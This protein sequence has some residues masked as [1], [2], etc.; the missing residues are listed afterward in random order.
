M[1]AAR[2][3]CEGTV[4]A[5]SASAVPDSIGGTVPLEANAVLKAAVEGGHRHILAHKLDNRRD[6]KA[7]LRLGHVH[8]VDDHH[9]STHTEQ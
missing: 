5:S 7:L 3:Q 8:V 2:A 1:S 6:A 9:E 4:P